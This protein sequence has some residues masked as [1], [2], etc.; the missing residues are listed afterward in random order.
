MIINTGV[1][2]AYYLSYV[3]VNGHASMMLSH[4]A[5]PTEPAKVIYQVGF[6]GFLDNGPQSVLFNSFKGMIHEEDTVAKALYSSSSHVR[7]KTYEISAAEM[8]KF[9]TIMNRDKQLNPETY[10]YGGFSK[11]DYRAFVSLRDAVTDKKLLEKLNQLT[12]HNFMNAKL[13]TVEIEHIQ[14]ALSVSKKPKLLQFFNN[15]LGEQVDVRDHA[16]SY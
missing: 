13:T 9:F 12:Q 10:V 7:H 3:E 1:F 11:M 8:E 14:H 5:T 15:S 4:Q 6:G 16:I 2:M